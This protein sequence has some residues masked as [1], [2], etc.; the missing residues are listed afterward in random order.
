[1]KEA[2][3]YQRV[4][5]QII[6]AFPNARI[7]RIEN[8][9]VDG[10]PDVNSCLRGVDVWMELKHIEKWPARATTPVL[11]RRGLRPEQINWHIRHRKAGGKSFIVMGVG[12]ETW[13]TDN[14]FVRTINEWTKA[15]WEMEGV[16]LEKFIKSVD[17]D[18]LI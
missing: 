14:E 18:N 7:D 3:L 16:L 8:G 1:M 10:M 9:L 13:V 11:G 6:A 12:H 2:G 15:E 5:R 17:S 4:R